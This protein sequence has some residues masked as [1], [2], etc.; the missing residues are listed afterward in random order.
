MTKHEKLVAANAEAV[1]LPLTSPNGDAEPT[2]H[3]RRNMLI[4]S[5]KDFDA[6]HPPE[7][8]NELVDRMVAEG[9]VSPTPPAEAAEEDY[10]D[11]DWC[12][13]DPC[14]VLREQPATA[15]YLNPSDAV[16]IRQEK[17]WDREEDSF[18]CIRPEYA[19]KFAKQLLKI[20]GHGEVEFSQR[21]GGGFVDLE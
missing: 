10:G 19:I 13:S 7:T 6:K 18:V 17:T 8:A 1:E 16:V 3:Q 9:K 11:F 5:T 2:P 14:I 12:R 15:I 4:E 20:A 21:S